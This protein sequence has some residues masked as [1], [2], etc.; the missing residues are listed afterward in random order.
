VIFLLNG[1]GKFFEK[2]I[3]VLVKYD[4][5]GSYF[6][7]NYTSDLKDLKENAII[8]IIRPK[9]CDTTDFYYELCSTVL[10]ESQKAT[11]NNFTLNAF[12]TYYINRQIPVPVTVGDET[13]IQL[14]VFG[15]PFE[16][17]SP[18]DFW[19]EKCKNIGRINVE[20]QQET[21]I[22]HQDQVALSGAL[23]ENGQLN[24]LNYFDSAKKTNFSDTYINGIVS[25]L[26]YPGIILV[27]GQS[28]NF[29]VG[30]NDNLVRINSDGT[31]QAASISNT[32]GKPQTKISG[33]FGCLLFDKNTISRYENTVQWLDSSRSTVVQHN[34]QQAIQ[35]TKADPAVGVVG[36]VDSWIRPKIKA[37][38]QYN[39]INGKTRY[40]HGIINPVNQE[41]ILTDFII[42]SSIY[43][44]SERGMNIFVPET[45][46]FNTVTKFW[47]M[48]Y[49]FVPQMYAQLQG[50]I[51][52]QQLFSFVN[53]IPYKHYSINGQGY[54]TIYGQQA[55]R[56][57]EVV[58]VIDG[59]NKKN[60]NNVS[61]YCKQAQYFCDRAITENDQETRI[62]LGNWLQSEYGWYA[63]VFCDLNT[64]FSANLPKQTG[65]L[66]IM[67]GNVMYGNFIIIRMVGNPLEDNNYSELQGVI[68]Y[69]SPN[70]I[71]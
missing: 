59:M 11:L 54:G 21:E 37:V 2:S 57:F 50:E 26:P 1:D 23:S 7:I 41:Y 14:R 12:D 68:A 5:E 31:A 67:E 51:S 28:D 30:F 33:N 20:N 19:G 48:W 53:G 25:V 8:R 61:Q 35:I 70:S 9:I 17:N 66:K 15:V 42:G 49:G 3:S 16:H 43:N 22:Y 44:N 63:P 6:L 34:Y 39:S 65:E 4:E 38:Q 45:I 60:F 47:R 58:A 71:S 62:L 69:A 18:S 29:I 24:F 40:F 36:G 32:F 52:A 27:I 56:V 55:N 13:Q 46:S 64:P 10:I